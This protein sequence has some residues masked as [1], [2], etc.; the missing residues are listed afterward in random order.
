MLKI[1]RSKGF[2]L[3][4]VLVTSII[5][6][7]VLTGVAMALIVAYRISDQVLS[8][9]DTQN[10][11]TAI[12]SNLD[13][14]VKNSSS[15]SVTG[16]VLKLTDLS[17]TVSYYRISGNKIEQSSDGTNY[18]KLIPSYPNVGIS[19]SFTNTGTTLTTLSVT[20]SVVRGVGTIALTDNLIFKCSQRVY[21]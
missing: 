3:I 8:K 5:V 7:F 15:L 10:V 18:T 4:E 14:K 13:S 2:T 16:G 11:L 1:K 6:G 21:S 20:I 17:G 9:T 19:G 12:I